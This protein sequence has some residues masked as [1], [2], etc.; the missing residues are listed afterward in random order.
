MLPII[1]GMAYQSGL[2][3][4]KPV[5]SSDTEVRKWRKANPLRH[6][7]LLMLARRATVTMHDWQF[8]LQHPAFM[9][10]DF[11][12]VW[13]MAVPVSIASTSAPDDSSLDGYLV[14]EPV[15]HV[16]DGYGSADEQNDAATPWEYEN[17][18]LLDSV[19]NGDEAVHRMKEMAVHFFG[20][21][22]EKEGRMHYR[23]F[24]KI[25]KNIEIQIARSIRARK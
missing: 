6:A 21:L 24:Q 5:Q 19:C 22:E 4:P 7:I 13:C 23:N 1:S 15:A 20:E 16:L 25:R 11:C 12:F 14:A 8:A 9:Y 2:F 18:D 17:G 3:V 10:E